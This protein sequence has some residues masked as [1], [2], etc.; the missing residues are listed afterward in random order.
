MD[1]DND[2]MRR[3]RLKNGNSPGAPSTAPRCGARTRSGEACRGPAMANGRCRMHGG[4]STGPR[5]AEGLARMRK[6]RTRTGL[7]TAEMREWRSELTMLQRITRATRDRMK[8]ST[9]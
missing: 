9:E 5:T 3:G 1:R 4:A 2:P 6:A 8:C 7:H